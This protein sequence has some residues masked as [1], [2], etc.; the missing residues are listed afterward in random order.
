MELDDVYDDYAGPIKCYACGATLELK[1]EEGKLKS[2]KLMPRAA[3][4]PNEEQ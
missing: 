3:R 1:T 2:V 4:P